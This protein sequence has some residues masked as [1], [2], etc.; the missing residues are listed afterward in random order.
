MSS[1]YNSSE[2]EFDMEEE[3]DLAVILAMHINK[4]TEARWFDYVLAENLEG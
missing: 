4:K 1:S 2:E 3:K